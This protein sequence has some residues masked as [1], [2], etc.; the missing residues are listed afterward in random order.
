MH[1]RLPAF[2]KFVFRKIYTVSVLANSRVKREDLS[3]EGRSLTEVHGNAPFLLLIIYSSAC[4]VRLHA[5]NE[6]FVYVSLKT[7]Y[8]TRIPF[9]RSSD[10]KLWRRF[11]D[12]QP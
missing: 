7:V 10:S 2:T 5:C 4:E 1:I 12:L 8:R 9:P 6:E 3:R 11:S